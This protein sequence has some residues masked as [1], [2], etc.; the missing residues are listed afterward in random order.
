VQQL[1]ITGQ[2][3]L[4]AD[5][6]SLRVKFVSTYQ[7][8]D[9]VSAVI[10]L[11]DYKEQLYIMTQLVLREFTG[12]YTFDE[13]LRQKD[14]IGGFVLERL[15]EREGELYVSFKDA[16]VKVADTLQILKFFKLK[17]CCVLVHELGR[18]QETL[19]SSRFF[20]AG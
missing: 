18:I 7:V 15:K 4:T 13:L 16:G 1:D 10:K 12:K 3:I 14:S 9:P 20:P 17:Q 5:K 6:V 2:E 19:C 8:A 11:K